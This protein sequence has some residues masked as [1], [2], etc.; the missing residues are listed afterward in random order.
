MNN[1]ALIYR[2]HYGNDKMKF[3]HLQGLINQLVPEDLNKDQK[4]DEWKKQILAVYSKQ[5]GLFINLLYILNE[6]NTFYISQK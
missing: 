6:F 3:Q 2:A 5:I 4:T 1:G